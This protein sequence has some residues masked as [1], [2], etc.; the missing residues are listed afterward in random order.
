M[1]EKSTLPHFGRAQWGVVLALPDLPVMTEHS[2]L[3]CR[4]M[5]TFGSCPGGMATGVLQSGPDPNVSGVFIDGAHGALTSGGNPIKLRGIV[6]G[7]MV[8]GRQKVL[9]AKWSCAV[10]T[11]EWEEVDEETSWIRALLADVEKLDVALGGG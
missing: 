6:L 1:G 2:L 10:L 11:L 8:G 7:T 3:K 9:A 5:R 4:S